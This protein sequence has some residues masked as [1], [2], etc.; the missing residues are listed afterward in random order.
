MARLEILDPDHPGSF[1]LIDDV[2]T[3]G[4]RPENSV[5]LHS[6]TVSGRHA[7]IRRV[8]RHFVLTD[9]GS[10]NGTHLNRE[11]IA[12]PAR[13]SHNDEIYF[14]NTPARFIDSTQV[15]HSDVGKK[16]VYGGGTV[17]MGD[18]ESSLA[19]GKS[20]ARKVRFLAEDKHT[21]IDSS[22]QVG[23]SFGRLE[24]NS[25][26]KLQAVLEISQKLVGTTDV[27]AILP[28]VLQILF[29][30][31][32]FADRGC[33]LLR[34]A[35]EGEL[36]PHALLHR[37]DQEDA[38]F[39][40]SRT[41]VNRVL[42]EKAALLSKD[43]VNDQVLGSI[44]S[45]VD[46]KIRS[47]ICAPLMTLHGEPFGIVS[48]DSQSQLGRFTSE[49][50]ELLIAV[51]GQAALAYENAQLFRS[52]LEKEK[53]DFE[54]ELARGVQQALLPE[55]VGRIGEY[56]FY[57]SYES[58]RAVGGDYYDFLTL[59]NGQICVSLG[60]V[61]GKGV[62]GALIMSRMHSCV[63]N[64][65]QHV[66]EVAPAMNAINE[67]MCRNAADGRFVT[68]VLALLDPVTN[69][70]TVSN[71]GHPSPV[72]RH[73]DGTLERFNDELFG[74]PI[75]VLDDWQ[76]QSETRMLRPGDT[77]VIITDGVDEAM[78][79]GGELY[80]INRTLQFIEQ[81]PSDPVELGKSLLDDVRAHAAGFPQSD[82]IT[83]FCFGRDRHE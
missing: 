38:T 80:G 72:I 62:P 65:M 39:R 68:F 81:G 34:E 11:K 55:H 22:L 19:A 60:D 3:I 13:L 43:A 47:I 78:N 23:S 48:L 30:L 6:V 36:V 10:R 42:H 5:V 35:P 50:L 74:P 25:S 9:I 75:G 44:D 46:L 4:R 16:T 57:A 15:T 56:S 58:A 21:S 17:V 52:Y 79:E 77:V 51:A 69:E 2:T 76:Y 49:D 45:V 14:G 24:A 37:R 64:T 66:H 20:G 53:Q 26:K 70:L 67:H 82:D 33:V 40:L 27:D 18:D 59:P 1:D 83:I 29:D 7:E 71:A 8:D 61:A 63:Q 54:L 28:N 73:A 32:P 12:S 31:F 41:I